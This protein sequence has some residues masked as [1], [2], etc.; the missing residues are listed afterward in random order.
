MKFVIPT[1]YSVMS[2]QLLS[3]IEHVI[4]LA[5]KG[6]ISTMIKEKTHISALLELLIRACKYIYSSYGVSQ[7]RIKLYKAS[8]KA[9]DNCDAAFK[10]FLSS[11][12]TEE[13]E[14]A[15]KELESCE[16]FAGGLLHV[17]TEI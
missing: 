4:S 12:L 1:S 7:E 9:L 10:R 14:Q 2:Q 3:N 15:K 17:L 16:Y 5:E 13:E 11:K 8:E 6:S